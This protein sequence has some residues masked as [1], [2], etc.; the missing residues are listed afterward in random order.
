MNKSNDKNLMERLLEQELPA[1]GAQYARYRRELSEKLRKIKREEKMM[2]LVSKIAWGVF[3]LMMI[4]GAVVDF[5][6]D[7]VPEFTRLSLM[8]ATMVTLAC[9][10]ALLAIY[11]INYRP[12]V[13]RGEQEVML[14]EL[15]RQLSELRAS[16]SAA[17]PDANEH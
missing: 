8:A 15:Q 5:N 11:L 12:R 13:S 9:A 17:K 4:I 10:V 6:R 3:G 16:E 14:L 2:R 7:R 1:T